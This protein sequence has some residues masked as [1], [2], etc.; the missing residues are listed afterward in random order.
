M[1]EEAEKMLNVRLKG[2]EMLMLDALCRREMRT[3]SGMIRWLIAR[4]Y[5]K[6]LPAEI[7][8]VQ[9]EAATTPVIHNSEV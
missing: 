9:D 4:E 8:P 6:T 2:P 5:Q 3:Q 7:L 1:A